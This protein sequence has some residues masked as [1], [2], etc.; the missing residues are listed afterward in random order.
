M[1]INPGLYRYTALR[2]YDR[3]TRL[4]IAGVAIIWLNLSSF[5]D[6]S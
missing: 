2:V 3:L 1:P 5:N 4:A 6:S